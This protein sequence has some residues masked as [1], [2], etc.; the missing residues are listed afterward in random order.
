MLRPLLSLLFVSLAALPAQIV[1]TVGGTTTSPSGTNR[2]KGSLYRVDTSVFLIDFEMHLN[3]PSPDT[4]TFF[5]YRHHSRTGPA[6]LEWTHQVQVT[7]GI[8]AAWYSTGPIAM[9]LV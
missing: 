4:L 1:E 9:P 5:L 2:G 7:G 3:V 6:T 8:G